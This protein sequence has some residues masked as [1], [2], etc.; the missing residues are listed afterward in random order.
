MNSHHNK[1]HHLVRQL[2]RQTQVFAPVLALLI[3][4]A[5]GTEDLGA[6]GS[7][8]AS[9]HQESKS[10]SYEFEVNGCN[11]GKHTVGTVAEYCNALK[12]DERNRYCAHVL[13][14]EAFYAMECSGTF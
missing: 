8:N 13:R 10:Y 4:S 1:N 5:C 7:A 6:E 2:I 3:L 11:T 14:E 12:D 9:S